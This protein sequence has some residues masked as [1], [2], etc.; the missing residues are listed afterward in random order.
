[1]EA[2]DKLAIEQSK[3]YEDIWNIPEPGVPETCIAT[4]D[5]D[6]LN[7]P[8]A[9]YNMDSQ[10]SRWVAPEEAE[11]NFYRQ[12]LTGDRTDNIHGCFKVGAATAAKL[13]YEGQTSGDK[14]S[15]V[16]EQYRLNM[17]KYPEQWITDKTPEEA[18]LEI[19]RLVY[20]VQDEEQ[21]LW[22]PPQ[23]TAA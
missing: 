13:I 2:D 9:H 19:A 11:V 8:G 5:K 14:W 18:A 6:L 17:E 1:M 4:I 22:E 7:V 16:L 21:L 15:T 3:A 23:R 12:I 20:M 10:L